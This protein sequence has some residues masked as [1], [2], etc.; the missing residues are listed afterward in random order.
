MLSSRQ[1]A[2]STHD[3]RDVAERHLE[4]ALHLY[5]RELGED[6]PSTLGSM[7][8]LGV[9]RRK[10]RQYDEAES[11]LIEALEGRRIK[12][13]DDHPDTLESRN[14]LIELYEAWDKPEKAEEWRAKLPHEEGKEK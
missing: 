3:H 4:R 11:L 2:C 6:D 8:A 5:Q 10:Q 13:G 7:N 14:N 1:L 9:L 12:F